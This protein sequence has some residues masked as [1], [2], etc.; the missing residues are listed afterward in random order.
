M[1]FFRNKFDNEFLILC[2]LIT[3]KG[4]TGAIQNKKNSFIDFKKYDSTNHVKVTPLVLYNKL[5][6]SNLNDC[7]VDDY[8]MICEDDPITRITA[9][10]E[11]GRTRKAEDYVCNILTPTGDFREDIEADEEEDET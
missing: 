4:M 9:T 10:W 3:P 8:C 7:N 5:E 1:T 6:S 2:E 11:D